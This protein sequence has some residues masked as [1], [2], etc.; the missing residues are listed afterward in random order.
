MLSISYG[1]TGTDLD[2]A[3]PPFQILMTGPD[4]ALES[5]LGTCALC[6]E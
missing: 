5:F 4:N 1:G 2:L 3:E 6:T